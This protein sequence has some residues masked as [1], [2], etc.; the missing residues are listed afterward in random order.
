MKRMK[1]PLRSILPILL[2][3]CLILGVTQAAAYFDSA[4]SA[5]ALLAASLEEEA[6]GPLV[7]KVTWDMAC[8]KVA[9][10]RGNVKDLV[11]NEDGTVTYICP[12]TETLTDEIIVKMAWTGTITLF[13][14]EGDLYNELVIPP[15]GKPTVKTA[16]TLT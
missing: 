11:V 4:A 16:K 15:L 14:Q 3:V 10:M 12:I 6:S 2:L 9:G 5:K 1:K 8:L 13:I 7:R